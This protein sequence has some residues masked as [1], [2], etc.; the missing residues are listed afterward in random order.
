MVETQVLFQ[1]NFT[2][3][4]SWLRC[5]D[6]ENSGLKRL[7]EKEKKPAD[8]LEYNRRL[9]RKKKKSNLED[10]WNTVGALLIG[11]FVL[12]IFHIKLIELKHPRG[13]YYRELPS[14]TPRCLS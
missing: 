5:M 9:G 1:E 11:W 7:T 3:G 8:R 10:H 13:G 12:I 4:K 6:Y 2:I 14:Y